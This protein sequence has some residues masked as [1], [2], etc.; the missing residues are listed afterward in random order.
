MNLNR[1]TLLAGAGA[2]ATASLAGCA[3]LTGQSGGNNGGGGGE[4]TTLS[5]VNWS[6][7]TEK[8]AFDALISR[9]TEA[10]PDITVETETVPYASIQQNIDSRF[11]SGNPPDLFRVSYID[12]GQYTS[13]GV[14]LDVSDVLGGAKAAEFVPGLYQG[15]VY[16][17]VPYGVPH[18][19]DTTAV[20]YRVDAFEAAGITDVP[21]TLAEAWS[22]EE[23]AEV[24]E[25]LAAAG[26]GE[27][28]PFVYNWQ[29]AGAYRWL[30]WLFQAGGRLLTEGLDAAAIDSDAGRRALDFTTGFFTGDWVAQNTSTKATTYADD[31]FIAGAA[32]MAFVGDFTL[33]NI[34]NEVDFEYGVLP[35]PRDVQAASDLGGNAIVAAADGPNTEAAARFCAFIA[36]AEQMKLYCEATG[37]LPTLTALTET[38]LDFA[39]RPDLMPTFVEQATTLTA[40]QVAQVTVP[41]FGRINTILGDELEQ[42]FLQGR[43]SADT[44]AALSAAIGQALR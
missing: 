38:E 36:E 12:I 18:Q 35:M 28:Y 11:Q 43:S 16:D 37:Q 17:G 32:A 41:G 1:R 13:Q 10:N 30:S 39:V 33:P 4:Q 5:F 9:F 2:C 29:D 20:L 8:A 31:E 21:T 26:S 44:L 23:F 19:I 6:G 24:A 27:Q 42:S 22:W 15:V 7:E 40:E 3:G 14:L 34:D 25:R